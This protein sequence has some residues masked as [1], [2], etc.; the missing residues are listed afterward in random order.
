[1]DAWNERTPE[2]AYLLNP[3]FCAIVIGECIEEYTKKK[4]E[5]F[6]FFLVY[7][8]LPIILHR[9]TRIKISSRTFMYSWIQRHPEVLVGFASRTENLKKI[10]NEAVLF[11]TNDTN[12]KIFGPNIITNKT[13]KTKV[14]NMDHEIKECLVKARHVGRWFASAGTAENIFSAWGIRP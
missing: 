10:T 3:A 5:G 1:M 12:I 14:E 11:L 2:V 4:R 8:I 6:P 7:L 9:N 13:I